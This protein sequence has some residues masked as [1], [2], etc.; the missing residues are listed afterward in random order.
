[1][2]EERTNLKDEVQLVVFTIG[3]EE[4]GIEVNQ[5]Q[6]IIKLLP[7]TR[8]PK[9]PDFIEG[10]INLRGNVIPVVNVHHRLG[11]EKRE[12]TEKT[13]IVV[14][15]VQRNSVGL[16]V[17]QVLEVLYLSQSAFEPPTVAGNL[18]N[19]A[20]IKGIGKLNGRLILLLDL[21]ALL[22]LKRPEVAS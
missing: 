3:A 7:I 19:T 13:R 4:Y 14:V 6:E 9:S 18:T 21:D 1:M 17:D 11:L 5:V 12:N 22:D 16:I 10:V 2:P 15:E 20:F 8:V